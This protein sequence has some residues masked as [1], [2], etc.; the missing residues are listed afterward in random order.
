MGTITTPTAS[1]SS[2][3]NRSEFYWGLASGPFYGPGA[4]PRKVFD[5]LREQGLDDRDAGLG[6]SF[7]CRPFKPS[8]RV[9]REPRPGLKAV[10]GRHPTGPGASEDTT[11]FSRRPVPSRNGEP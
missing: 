10:K 5:G 3:G 9:G 2:A 11:K 7:R 4:M 8:T 1:R 6:W